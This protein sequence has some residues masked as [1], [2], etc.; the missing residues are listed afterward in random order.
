MGYFVKEDSQ[1]GMIHVGVGRIVT[2][3]SPVLRLFGQIEVGAVGKHDAH[4]P[5]DLFSGVARLFFFYN[6]N[7]EFGFFTTLI[8]LV[9]LVTIFSK[10]CFFGLFFVNN[11]CFWLFFRPKNGNVVFKKAKFAK[12]F[13]GLEKI[14]PPWPVPRA[15]W[16]GIPGRSQF[17]WGWPPT[18]APALQAR[19]FVNPLM[20]KR[21]FRNSI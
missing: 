11:W 10:F 19:A 13:R 3:S 17:R 18:R 5:V 6:K 21:Y 2:D 7:W 20:P 8:V 1:T 14:W 4:E 9:F 12:C 15:S 16:R